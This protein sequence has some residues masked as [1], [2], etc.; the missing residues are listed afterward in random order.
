[1]ARKYFRSTTKELEE[2]FQENQSDIGILKELEAELKHRNKKS[3]QRLLGDVSDRLKYVK[4]L[5]VKQ[6]FKSDQASDPANIQ[7][8]S[9]IKPTAPNK[10]KSVEIN[11]DT[12]STPKSLSSNKSKK[13]PNET[14]NNFTGVTLDHKLGFI[15]HCGTIKDVPQRIQFKTSD[16]IRLDLTAETPISKRFSIALNALIEEMRKQGAGMKAYELFDG[17]SVQLDGDGYG[18]K[19]TTDSEPQVFEG[20]CVQLEINGAIYDGEIVSVIGNKLLLSVS[21]QLGNIPLCV[22][23]VDNTSML[24]ALAERL[25]KMS[26]SSEGLNMELAR[27]VLN[28]AGDESNNPKEFSDNNL[29]TQQ[30]RAVSKILTENVTYLWGPP[31]TGKT[32]TL[33]VAIK[34]L[35]E[36]NKRILICSNTNQAVDQ[37]LLKMCKT[38]KHNHDALENG[39]VIRVGS[40]HLQELASDW[41]QYV[42][43]EGVVARKSEDLVSQLKALKNKLEEI[44]KDSEKL[45]SYFLLFEFLDNAYKSIFTLNQKHI[46]LEEDLKRSQQH[47]HDAKLKQSELDAERTKILESGSFKRLLLRGIEKVNNDLQSLSLKLTSIQNSCKAAEIKLINFLADSEVAKENQRVDE[48]NKK[49]TG[50]NREQT[51]KDYKVVE[52]RIREV[53]MEIS[54]INTKLEEIEK[55]V[56]NDARIVGTTVTKLYLSHSMFSKF[57]VIIMD[58]ASMIPLPAVYYASALAKESVVISGDFR[59]LSPI[60]T[61]KEKAIL[62]EIGSDIFF[63]AGIQ[64]AFENKTGLKRTVLLNTQYRMPENVCRLVSPRMYRSELLTEY[65]STPVEMPKPFNSNLVVVDTSS[66]NPFVNKKGGSKYNLLNAILARNI[67]SRLHESNFTGSIGVCTPYAAQRD[68]INKLLKADNLEEKIESGTVHRFQGDEKDVVLFDVPDSYG[69]HYVGGFAQAELPSDSGSKLFNVAVSRSKGNFI[70]L[71][72]LEY[73]D[74]KLPANAFLREILYEVSQRGQVLDGADILALRPPSESEFKYGLSFNTPLEAMKSGAFKQSEF[75]PVFAND[76][77]NAKETIAIFSG[78]ITTARVASYERMFRDCIQRGVK[79]RC[80]T[81]PPSRN[82]SMSFEEG[83]AALNKLEEI[84]CVVDTRWD[85]H[86][87]VI[88]IDDEIAWVGSLNPLSH[89]SSTSEVMLRITGREIAEQL[90]EFMSIDSNGMNTNTSNLSVRKENPSCESCGSRSVYRTGKYGPFWECENTCGWKKSLKEKGFTK[91]LDPS[92]INQEAP[93]CPDCGSDMNIKQSR[94]GAFWSC[95]KYP[96]CKCKLKY[97]GKK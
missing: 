92:S 6:S 62:D 22:M 29:N 73:L 71:A 65:K 59:Q 77:T 24:K 58:E 9:P 3:A 72:N 64:E 33:A 17:H 47:L 60:V 32:Q 21:D 70:I 78:F 36:S 51:T 11:P 81:R 28:N 69:E 2:L 1:M 66:L 80:V 48:L 82:G 37:V 42:T 53:S 30:N 68:L 55:N 34:E 43:L 49:L 40:I 86:E 45:K 67:C 79:I 7:V 85:I 31:G 83:V 97:D 84:G 88:L 91:N 56:L 10:T 39:E 16:K 41:K 38:L 74:S 87:K 14:A 19:F 57:D 76:A 8:N 95:S 20:A 23:K 46:L 13:I 94:Y 90:S 27:M 25:D 50:I 4:T 52:D 5:S 26:D 12:N 54:V 35:F 75:D 61:S 44:E 96:E 15:R 89:S 63:K 18:L 93:K